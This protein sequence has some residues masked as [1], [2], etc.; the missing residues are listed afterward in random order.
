M[1]LKFGQSRFRHSVLYTC[2][3]LTIIVNR[4]TLFVIRDDW[5]KQLPGKS[6]FQACSVQDVL[7]TFEKCY[8][9]KTTYL[10][11]KRFARILCSALFMWKRGRIRQ[12]TESIFNSHFNSKL[13]VASRSFD[14][15][16]E[17]RKHRTSIFIT[18]YAYWKTKRNEWTMPHVNHID[19]RHTYR[20]S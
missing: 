2:K 5:R 11:E 6:R 1:F 3:R 14:H 20:S 4:A 10:K 19:Q 7:E 16:H 9:S 12:P 15:S 8:F 13:V 17:E 18:R